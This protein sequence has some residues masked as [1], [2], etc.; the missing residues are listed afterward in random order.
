MS[1]DVYLTLDGE[2][3]YDNNITHNMVAMAKA[4]GVYMPVWRP[5]E[6]GI[7]VAWQLIRPLTH[8]L[9]VM[10][11][12]RET[13]MKHEPENGWGAYH[14]FRNFLEKYLEACEKNPMA[15]VGACR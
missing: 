11:Y 3:V 10:H 2:T 13:C 1:L 6:I 14:V 12:E 7:E 4:I 5:E 9:A 15:S 8:A